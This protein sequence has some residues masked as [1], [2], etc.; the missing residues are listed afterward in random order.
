MMLVSVHITLAVFSW[1]EIIIS[2]FYLERER[3]RERDRGHVYVHM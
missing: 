1:Q 2:T 3:E